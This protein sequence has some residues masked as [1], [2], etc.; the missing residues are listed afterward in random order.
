[1]LLYFYLIAVRYFL[2]FAFYPL[3][4]RT[5][6]GTNIK[7]AVFMAFAGF[8]GAVGIALSLSLWA[9]VMAGRF[10]TLPFSW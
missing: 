5:G 10:Y 7:E 9:D 6:L 8:R 3:T 1:M 4:S 2:V